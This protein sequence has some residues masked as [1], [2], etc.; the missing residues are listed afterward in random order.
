[1]TKEES[2][3]LASKLSQ[4]YKTIERLKKQIA[5]NETAI[6]KP[7]D[8]RY[9]KYT[10]FRF[11]WPFLIYSFISVFGFT[12][13]ALLFLK[14]PALNFF[15]ALEYIG[16]IVILI[17]GGVR[18]TKKRNELNSAASQAVTQRL[19]HMDQLKK[20]T[21]DLKSKLASLNQNVSLMDSSIPQDFKKSTRMEKVRQ[22][23]EAG[24]AESFE[25][26][27][28]ICRNMK[29]LRQQQMP[30]RARAFLHNDP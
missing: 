16:P 22:L 3:A 30:G 8:T 20:D 7:V 24:K 14:S 5:D 27:F 2:I 12:F 21:E 26:A 11:F 19:K 28:E 18:A 17:I 25:E 13:I 15:I 1:M 6:R 9:K 23:M 4:D 10:W 29:K